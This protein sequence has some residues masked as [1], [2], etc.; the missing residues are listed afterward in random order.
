MSSAYFRYTSTLCI[1]HL[2][3]ESIH[4]VIHFPYV[5]T[6]A[7]IRCPPSIIP[8]LLQPSNFPSLK[9]IHYL[10]GHPGSNV[11]HRRSHLPIR[12]V[13]PNY[14]H[15]FYNTMVESGHGIKSDTLL[16]TY[17]SKETSQDFELWIPGYGYMDGKEYRSKL[18]HYINSPT[19]KFGM[20]EMDS[21]TRI[22]TSTI[23][24]SPSHPINLYL[25]KQTEI[26]FLKTLGL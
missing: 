26:K 11:L 25:K 21:I 7:L 13:F 8:H 17:L 2:Q 6:L 16:S 4:R 9:E 14:S 3:P 22:H 20:G 23:N 12:W 19:C 18:I 24:P 1:Y 15:S 10:S 5:N